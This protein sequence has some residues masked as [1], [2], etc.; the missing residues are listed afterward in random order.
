M[1]PGFKPFTVTI[2]LQYSYCI[3]IVLSWHFWESLK[4]F[5]NIVIKNFSCQ[6]GILFSGCDH[7][8]YC[9]CPLVPMLWQNFMPNGQHAPPPPTSPNLLMCSTNTRVLALLVYLIV[10]KVAIVWSLFFGSRWIVHRFR[11]WLHLLPHVIDRTC[12]CWTA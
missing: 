10:M 8:W 1:T 7:Q 11:G 2:Q 5:K 12:Y 3:I 6:F 9:M 4:D